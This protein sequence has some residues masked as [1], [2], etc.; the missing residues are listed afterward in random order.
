[1]QECK[2]RTVGADDFLAHHWDLHRRAVLEVV[3]LG[4]GHQPA[5]A[6]AAGAVTGAVADQLLVGAQLHGA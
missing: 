2:S 5:G 3:Q 4:D 1:M 6:A